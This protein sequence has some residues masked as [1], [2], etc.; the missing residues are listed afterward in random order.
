MWIIYYCILL[1]FV[2]T[3]FYQFLTI[4]SLR[5]QIKELKKELNKK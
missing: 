1:F 4:Y 3:I 2:L 5:E